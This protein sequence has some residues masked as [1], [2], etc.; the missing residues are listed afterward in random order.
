MVQIKAVFFNAF[1]PMKRRGGTSTHGPHG[2]HWRGFTCSAYDIVF[3]KPKG[4][5][6]DF[7]HGEVITFCFIVFISISLLWGDHDEF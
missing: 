5:I 3:E 2:Y 1:Y 7:S 4:Y 6:Y